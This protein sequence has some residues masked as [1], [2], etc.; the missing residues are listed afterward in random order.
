MSKRRRNKS[1]PPVFKERKSKIN[2]IEYQT[3]TPFGNLVFAVSI[4]PEMVKKLNSIC[5]TAIEKD[6]LDWGHKLV[7]NIKN[8]LL[9]TSPSP[10]DRG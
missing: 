8:C 7:G 6:K 10:R 9:Y 5:D 2:D 1:K 3:L 4:S